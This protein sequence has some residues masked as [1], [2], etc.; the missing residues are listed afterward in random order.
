M[1]L[2][3]SL[4][5]R[6]VQ[7]SGMAGVIGGLSVAFKQITPD[8]VINLKYYKARVH[9]STNIFICSFYFQNNGDFFE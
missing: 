9:V 8:Q 4:A 1:M 7:F 5:F 6:M 2:L 3:N